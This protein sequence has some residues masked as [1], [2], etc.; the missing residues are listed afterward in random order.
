MYLTEK[1]KKNASYGIW[2]YKEMQMTLCIRAVWSESSLSAF[3]IVKDADSEHLSD[4][5]D[6]RLY[7]FTNYGS[8]IFTDARDYLRKMREEQ[9]RDG[10]TAV[11][12]WEEVLRDNAYKLGDE[13]KPF[14]F[15]HSYR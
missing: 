7:I 1:K 12:L 6:A 9:M 11:R 2:S 4:C 15:T 3:W 8:F 10:E 14:C 5:A 13:C